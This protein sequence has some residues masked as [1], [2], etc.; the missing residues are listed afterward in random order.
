MITTITGL[1]AITFG[2][3]VG[4]D[5]PQLSVKVVPQFVLA[6]SMIFF[7]LSLRIKKYELLL[8]S[9]NDIELKY[10]EIASHKYDWQTLGYIAFIIA[11][12]LL[13]M[14]YVIDS[15]FNYLE[16]KPPD[17]TEILLN[18]NLTLS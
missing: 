15:P 8:Q 3:I 1:L 17:P 18:G 6:L 14:T 2:I 4:F 9:P 12:I 13:T 16:E 5:L 10:N 11:L 7:F